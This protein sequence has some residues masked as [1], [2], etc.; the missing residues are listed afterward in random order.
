LNRGVGRLLAIAKTSYARNA[1]R[2][3]KLANVIETGIGLSV[4]KDGDKE[5]VETVEV[6]IDNVELGIERDSEGYRERSYT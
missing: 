5:G 3:G 2:N 6:H 1:I 4:T